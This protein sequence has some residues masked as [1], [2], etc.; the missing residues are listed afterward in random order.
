MRIWKVTVLLAA[1][2]ALLTFACAQAAPPTPTPSPTPTAT[3]TPLPTNTPT[4]APT[5]TPTPTPPPTATATPTSTSTPASPLYTVDDAMGWLRQAGLRVEVLDE[6]VVREAGAGT[7]AF[8]VRVDD[9]YRVWVYAFVP[10]LSSQGVLSF[11]HVY[12]DF[13]AETRPTPVVVGNVVV[14]VRGT[15]KPT[16]EKV[17][18]ALQDKAP[19][20]VQAP[21]G[22]P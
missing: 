16:L 19:A 5:A 11:F 1:V 15:D 7:K 13:V 22:L 10:P 20:P 2:V 4:P 21:F 9:Y 14:L 12:A 3:V 8:H 18:S 6:T 17:F